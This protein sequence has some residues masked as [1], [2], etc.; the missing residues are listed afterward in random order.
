VLRHA[1]A[2][3]GADAGAGAEGMLVLVLSLS[4][5]LFI[6]VNY[7]LFQA[8]MSSLLPLLLI[9]YRLLM[10]VVFGRSGLLC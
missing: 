7:S 10:L 2:G 4:P 8:R 9:V 5:P 3:A 6:N 1:G